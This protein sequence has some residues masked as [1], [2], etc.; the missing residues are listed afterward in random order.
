[1]KGNWK[2]YS[3]NGHCVHHCDSNQQNIGT[4]TIEDDCFKL[5]YNE[6]CCA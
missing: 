5:K 6:N 2:L 3:V 4:F 1:M